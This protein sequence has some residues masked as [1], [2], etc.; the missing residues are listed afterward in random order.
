MGQ[1]KK[2]FNHHVFSLKQWRKARLFDAAG[3]GVLCLRFDA[4]KTVAEAET[5]A[6]QIR[7]EAVS[8]AK[9]M[10]VQAEA[11]GK[12]ELLSARTEA[13][14]AVRREI[15]AAEKQGESQAMTQEEAAAKELAALEKTAQANM[16]KAVAIILERIVNG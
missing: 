7:T 11:A 6:K 5:R 14:E 1:S 12:A 9:E 10:L 15:A 8:R 13:R 3:K 16:D 2:S 4:I